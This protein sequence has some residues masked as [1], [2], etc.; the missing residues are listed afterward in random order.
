MLQN[1]K[2]KKSLSP[3]VKIILCRHKHSNTHVIH[4]G[5][6]QHLAQFLSELAG[7]QPSLRGWPEQKLR[8]KKW[9]NPP[10]LPFESMN[11]R[12]KKLNNIKRYSALLRGSNIKSFERGISF[13]VVPKYVILGD[14]W[15]RNKMFLWS[16]Y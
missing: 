13:S 10:I 1:I 12:K 15:T 11:L 8:R 4:R 3:P 7:L 16:K 14:S 6:S 9:F 5:K 2:K